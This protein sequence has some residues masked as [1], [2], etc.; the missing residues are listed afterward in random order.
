MCGCV[1]VCVSLTQA[2]GSNLFSMWWNERRPHK[3]EVIVTGGR[4]SSKSLTWAAVILIPLSITE[5]TA[6]HWAAHRGSIRVCVLYLIKTTQRN[7][8]RAYYSFWGFPFPEVCFLAWEKC[9][10]V[11]LSGTWWHRLLFE[12]SS[13]ETVT[14][15]TLNTNMKLD[16]CR[17][18]PHL[19]VIPP[20]LLV[21]H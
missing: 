12:H 19:Q 14:V 7:W 20:T 16:I 10:R 6:V 4:A 11:N 15:E 13:M 17:K 2:C 8:K 21:K 3:E 5:L 18:W 1:C 9:A